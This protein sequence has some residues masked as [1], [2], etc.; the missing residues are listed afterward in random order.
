M[1][2]PNKRDKWEKLKSL[3]FQKGNFEIWA[4]AYKCYTDPW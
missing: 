2:N 3:V 4:W 1:Q